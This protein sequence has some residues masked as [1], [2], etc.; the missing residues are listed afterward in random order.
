MWKLSTGQGEVLLVLERG[1]MDQICRLVQ[2]LNS[3]GRMESRYHG[4]GSLALLQVL[5][6]FRLM[7][8]HQ[9]NF[10]LVER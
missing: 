1:S 5:L 3:A 4:P 6:P 7:I 8:N 2:V 10:Y 9:M